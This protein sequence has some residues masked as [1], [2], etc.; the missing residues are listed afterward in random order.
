M[1]DKNTRCIEGPGPVTLKE[2]D[3]L[4]EKIHTARHFF[5]YN[6]GHFPN[7]LI[8]SNRQFYALRKFGP[9][10]WQAAQICTKPNFYSLNIIVDA[11]GDYPDTPLVG[12]IE[13]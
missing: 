10:S 2:C 4:I 8:L 12:H 7:T 1:I 13:F 5:A 11:R 6:Q 3:A 9:S